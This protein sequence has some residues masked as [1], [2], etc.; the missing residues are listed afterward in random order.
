MGIKPREMII[1]NLILS[2]LGLIKKNRIDQRGRDI[3]EECGYPDGDQPAPFYWELYESVGIANRV[4]NVFP[5]ECWSVYPELTE[6]DDVEYTPFEE[7]WNKLNKDSMIWSFLNRGDELSG[8]GN[9]GCMFL[10]FADGNDPLTPVPGVGDDGNPS[11]DNDGNP[12]KV[13][14]QL[15]FMRT[16]DASNVTV[17][18]YEGDLRNPRYGQP[19]EYQINVLNPALGMTQTDSHGN[20]I[21]QQTTTKTTLNVHWSRVIHLADNRKSSEIF[22]M[23]RMK[24]VLP[25]IMDIRKIRG[26]SA[27]MFWQG[28]FPGYSVE[29]NPDLGIEVELDKESVQEEFEKWANGLQRYLAL[30]GTSIKSL[31]PQVADPSH[32][33]D[34]QYRSI[35]A[36]IGVPQRILIGAESAHLASTQDTGTWNRRLSKR[37][38]MYLT[39]YV[40]KPFVERMI[41]AGVLPK[42]STYKVSWID[43]NTM[44]AKEKADVALKQTQS[45][46]T[47]VTGGVEQIMPVLEFYVE[48]LGLT[49]GQAKAILK[50]ARRSNRKFLTMEADPNSTQN[51]PPEPPGMGGPSG[52]NGKDNSNGGSP[53]KLPRPVGSPGTA[54]DGSSNT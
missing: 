11:K 10:G 12:V 4:V 35:G 37:Q 24:P 21:A 43:L 47:Y 26:G 3:N 31:A 5:E 51:K 40:I 23:P 29:T 14:N 1:N 18:K 33:L 9:F 22:G 45:M 53:K 13:E 7:E 54:P 42:P 27:E 32:H 52:G 46:M 49:V 6:T 25:E 20:F 15:L 38:E 41:M 17:S 39:P 8:I 19:V 16:F 28:A 30:V 2:R 34:E 48:T 50:A 36:T 44:S